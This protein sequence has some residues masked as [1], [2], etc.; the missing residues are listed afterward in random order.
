MQFSLEKFGEFDVV[1][2]ELVGEDVYV[3]TDFL[4]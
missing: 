4:W 2:C 3:V 1:L